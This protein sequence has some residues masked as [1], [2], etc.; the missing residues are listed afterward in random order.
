MVPGYSYISE[1]Q[2]VSDPETLRLRGIFDEADDAVRAVFP[3][4]A[5][6]Y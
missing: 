1:F 2:S 4:D 5:P 3:T 6:D